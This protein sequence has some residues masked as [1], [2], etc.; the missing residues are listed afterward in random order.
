M[1]KRNEKMISEFEGLKVRNRNLEAI[2]AGLKQELAVAKVEERVR[3]VR[4]ILAATEEG[5]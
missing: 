1:P 4:E 5:K 3:I 2:V